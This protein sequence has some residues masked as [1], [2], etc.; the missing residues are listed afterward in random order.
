MERNK[1]KGGRDRHA[2]RQRRSTDRMAAASDT[3]P[4]TNEDM[5]IA[6]RPDRQTCPDREAERESLA[7]EEMKEV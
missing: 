1:S 7:W 5:Q 3:E 6:T 2:D 4:K